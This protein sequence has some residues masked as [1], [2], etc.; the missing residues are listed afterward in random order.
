MRS[1]NIAAIGVAPYGGLW[2][3]FPNWNAGGTSTF[4][5]HPLNCATSSLFE[6]GAKN[7][8]APPWEGRMMPLPSDPAATIAQVEEANDN[9]Q[10]VINAIRPYG[11]TP[12]AA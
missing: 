12:I 8:A 5:G 2:S 1:C 3:Y 11:A 10:L 9:L 4:T 7:P 6:V